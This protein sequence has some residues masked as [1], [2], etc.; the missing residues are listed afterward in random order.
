MYATPEKKEHVTYTSSLMEGD[1]GN[2]E[3]QLRDR[4]EETRNSLSVF[5]I[6]DNLGWAD[7][8]CPK[9]KGRGGGKDWR[10]SVELLES[11]GGLQYAPGLRR[12]LGAEGESCE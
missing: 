1:V 8:S 5:P 11:E 2:S 12:A 9:K 4:G 7:F 6:W 10:G 3:N